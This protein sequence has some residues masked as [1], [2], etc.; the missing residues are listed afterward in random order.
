V[1]FT[2]RLKPCPDENKSE[3][4]KAK[5]LAT[6]SGLRAGRKRALHR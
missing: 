2:A 6:P 3:G 1:A 5:V 4:E